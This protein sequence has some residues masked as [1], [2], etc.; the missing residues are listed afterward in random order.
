[1]GAGSE[2][3]GGRPRQNIESKP[4]DG[5]ADHQSN[6]DFWILLGGNDLRVLID[7]C[8]LLLVALK[9]F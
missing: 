9:E 4:L 8:T 5:M 3:H 7:L 1:M 2:T 6:V